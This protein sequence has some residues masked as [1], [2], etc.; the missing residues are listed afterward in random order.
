MLDAYKELTPVV[1]GENAI[2]YLKSGGGQSGDAASGCCR[3]Y[4]SLVSYDHV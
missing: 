2:K 3:S 4:G 1:Y